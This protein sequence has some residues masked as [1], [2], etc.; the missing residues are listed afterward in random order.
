MILHLEN[1]KDTIRKLL[2]L[3]T[4]FD[5]VSGYLMN[6]KKSTTFVYTYNEKSK[7]KIR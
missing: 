5:K 6:T 4:E 2:E 1:P 7:S 3:T